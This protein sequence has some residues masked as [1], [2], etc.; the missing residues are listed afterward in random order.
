MKL[1][2]VHFAVIVC[3]VQGTLHSTLPGSVLAQQ[4]CGPMERELRLESLHYLI[5]L[6][7]GEG[8]ECSVCIAGFLHTSNLSARGCSSLCRR[9]W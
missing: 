9:P 8:S 3:T 6:L 2:T 4:L 1:S 5:K 7:D